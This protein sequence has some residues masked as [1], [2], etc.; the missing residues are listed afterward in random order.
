[1]TLDLN[2]DFMKY[3]KIAGIAS[4]VLVLGALVNLTLNQVEWGLD[5]TGG[6][7]VEVI[8][9]GQFLHIP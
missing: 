8:Y 4:I 6:S 2:I 7:L 1:M 3:R 9:P 5:F